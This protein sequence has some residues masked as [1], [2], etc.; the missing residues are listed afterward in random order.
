MD[1]IRKIALR[2]LIAVVGAA[3][4]YAII[5]LVI[6]HELNE[7]FEGPRIEA[8]ST[9]LACPRS[10]VSISGD[11]ARGCGKECV[12]EVY[13]SSASWFSSWV[14]KP[15]ISISSSSAR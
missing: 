6:R 1:I 11:V 10:D 5:V 13:G 14:C 9:A 4:V 8:A 2:L 12:L 7:M 3:V 15:P